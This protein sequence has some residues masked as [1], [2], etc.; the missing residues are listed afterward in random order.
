[1]KASNSRRWA[2]RQRNR[3]KKDPPGRLIQRAANEQP[4]QTRYHRQAVS[5][6][7]SVNGPRSFKN[8]RVSHHH[9]IIMEPSHNT[10][11]MFLLIAYLMNLTWDPILVTNS[12]NLIGL[13]LKF[14]KAVETYPLDL[15]SPKPFYHASHS[16]YD[17]SLFTWSFSTHRSG[18][19]SKDR[20]KYDR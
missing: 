16:R 15:T 19:R 18:C 6:D 10:L 8:C 1:V 11:S 17:K 2:D 12:P 9:P 13:S 20:A 7:Q 3:D 4:F 14:G 5:I